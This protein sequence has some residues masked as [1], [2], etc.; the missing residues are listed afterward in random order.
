M[1][2]DPDSETGLRAAIADCL[3]R[4]RRALTDTIRVVAAQEGTVLHAH[5]CAMAVPMLYAHWEG[6]AKEALQLY[7]EFLEH[8]A[9]AQR[10][11]RASLLA[12]SWSGRSESCLA[13]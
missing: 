13:R 8:S 4:R 3:D 6:F 2:G 9:V 11:V 12:Y 5:A 7:I 1:A 10:E